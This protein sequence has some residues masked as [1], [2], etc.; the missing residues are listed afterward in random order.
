MIRTLFLICGASFVL[1]VACFAGAAALGAPYFFDHGWTPF[2]RDWNIDLDDGWRNH[3]RDHWRARHFDDDN[4]DAS[5]ATPTT[6][7]IAWSGGDGLDIDIPADVQFTAGAGPGKITISG[8]KGTVDRVTLSGSHLQFSGDD[9]DARR[10]TIAMTAPS[11][12]RFSLSGDE[13]LGLTGLA[14]DELDIDVSGHATVNAAGKVRA[15]KIEISGDGDVD[16]GKL[17][18]QDARVEIDGSGRAAIAPTASADLHISGSGEVNLLTH[19]ANVSSDV[20]G[21]GRIVQG[22]P[23]KN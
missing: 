16:L 12:S 8:P 18:A 1:C 13:T 7:E 9:D 21:S 17:A 23:A 22:Q 20:S 15:A 10:V 4:G 5:D 19:P 6:R 14:Q 2:D 11:L 3:W